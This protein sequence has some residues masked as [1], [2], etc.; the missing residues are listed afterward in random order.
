MG[1]KRLLS[2]QDIRGQ[3][4][5]GRETAYALLKVLPVVKVGT[6]R[7]VRRE[8]LEAFLE[9]ASRKGMNLRVLVRETPRG[10]RG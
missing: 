5:L 2:A 8:D 6:R 3:Y 10:T 1:E 4:G 7:L 9:D